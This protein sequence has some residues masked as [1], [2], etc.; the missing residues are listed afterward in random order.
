MALPDFLVEIVDALSPAD[1]RVA[2]VAD[3][4]SPRP[5]FV[6]SEAVSGPPDIVVSV[7]AENATPRP[8]FRV[9]GITAP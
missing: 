3:N 9:A 2:I 6:M 4:A 8:D 1:F 7:V 5:D